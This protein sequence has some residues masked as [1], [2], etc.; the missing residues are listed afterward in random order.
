MQAR[1]WEGV[2]VTEGTDLEPERPS[3]FDRA[4]R[5][6]M[7]IIVILAVLV[8]ALPFISGGE[9][10]TGTLAFSQ[11]LYIAPML[12]VSS[13]LVRRWLT[14]GS[15]E[16]L[17]PRRPGPWIA[18]VIF[19]ILIACWAGHYLILDGYDLSRDEQMANFDTAIFRRGHLF[20]PIPLLWR[21]ISDALNLVFILPI[22]AREY[23]VSSYLPVHAEFRALLSHVAD[24]AL[25]SPLMAAAGGYFLWQVSRRIWPDSNTTPL[26]CVFLYAC[27]SQVLLM[28]MTAYS[29]SMHFALNML[30]LW[31][32]LIDRPRTHALVIAVGFFATGI[33]QPF[34]HAMFVFPFLL[35][36]LGQRR[37]KLLG[38]YLCA[39]AIIG[40]FWL[41]WP[42]W[43]SSHG[44]HAAVAIHG[45]GGVGFVDRL[46]TVIR[47]STHDGP[48]I[49]AANLLRFICW[50]HP[51]LL[52]LAIVGTATTF[53]K[54]GLARALAIGFVL[55]IVVTALILPWQGYGWGY[56]Y[57]H[58]ALGCAIL[59]A[60]F[61]WRVLE[62]QRLDLR[63]AMIR[64]SLMAMFLVFPFY[65]ATA[66]RVVSPLATLHR[67]ITKIPADIVIVDTA[68]APYSDDLVVNRSDLTNR[69]ILL[70][71]GSLKPAELNQICRMG[72]IAFVPGERLAPISKLFRDKLPHGPTHG[73]AVLMEHAAE[74]HCNVRA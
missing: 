29:M 39:Y 5:V 59:L 44:S 65:A 68:A 71:A 19:F 16:S 10:L 13:V 37:W 73:M 34:F 20:E 67:E 43:I 47:N 62:D 4:Y 49:M 41:A 25:A 51:L 50:E 1:R 17:W 32:F 66:H 31:L 8:I 3:A 63:P 6:A 56:R 64:T 22:G 28:G 54:Q 33:H 74:A 2:G 15:E 27:S 45:T 9:R 60:G 58:P 55:P 69:P 72:S 52:P 46:R 30:W 18:G 57:V 48:W 38:C 61:G 36:L 14:V 24:P 23:W 42:I 26:V 7:W 40:A 70:L 12:L 53:R 21:P 35:I 11:D